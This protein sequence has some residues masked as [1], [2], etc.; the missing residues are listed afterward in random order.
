MPL[1]LPRHVGLRYSETCQT[2]SWQQLGFRSERFLS[3]TIK[4]VKMFH[5][6]HKPL[7]S[8]SFPAVVVAFSLSLSLFLARCHPLLPI[9]VSLSLS[10]S[11]PSCAPGYWGMSSRC[12]RFTRWQH[13]PPVS[14]LPFTGFIL[15]PAT[16]PNSPACFLKGF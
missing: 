6:V 1:L 13:T 9:S 15:T 2:A 11:F 14:V 16:F 4:L 8:P 10:L 12:S 5:L 7:T 3:Q